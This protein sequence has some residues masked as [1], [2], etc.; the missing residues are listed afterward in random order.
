[1][2]E[3]GS[4]HHM[5]FLKRLCLNHKNLVPRSRDLT[6]GGGWVSR[7]TASWLS[8]E[9]EE[10]NEGERKEEIE[11]EIGSMR[12]TQLPQDREWL[13]SSSWS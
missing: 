6:G 5:C 12:T 4:E 9:K 7:A 10:E 8:Q 3:R 13:Q 11:R 2:G 1:M